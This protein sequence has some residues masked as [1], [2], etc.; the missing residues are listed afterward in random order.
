MPI[1]AGYPFYYAL[2]SAQEP[3]EI[4]KGIATDRS[5]PYVQRERKRTRNRWR[6]NDEKNGNVFK[7]TYMTS[8]YAV[9]SDQGGVLQPIQQHSWDVTW[10]SVWMYST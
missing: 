10:N 8:K 7:T 6:Y 2:A 9:G 3:N 1:H 5:Q 4:L